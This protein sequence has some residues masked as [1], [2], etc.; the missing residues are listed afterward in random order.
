MSQLPE[1]TDD[2]LEAGYISSDESAHGVDLAE[3][4]RVKPS[5]DVWELGKL[6]LSKHKKWKENFCFNKQAIKK[7]L[8][9][10]V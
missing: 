2:D 4:L 5:P 3:R 8:L 7:Y 9:Q 10:N 1:D 6:L